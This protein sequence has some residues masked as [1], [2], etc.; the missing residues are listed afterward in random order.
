VVGGIVV[1]LWVGSCKGDFEEGGRGDGDGW[2]YCHW[3]H[4]GG[5]EGG[6][7]ERRRK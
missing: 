7:S 6:K 1:D 2:T 5:I 4:S 3:S